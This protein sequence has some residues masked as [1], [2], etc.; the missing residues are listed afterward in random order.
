MLS[1]YKEWFAVAALGSTVL[2]QVRP[3]YSIRQSYFLTASI[4]LLLE[5]LAWVV[6][7]VILW[8][9]YLS[10]LRHLP[11]PSGGSFL[12]GHFKAIRK[13][14][15]GIPAR[16]WLNTIPNDGLIRY[17][18]LG[19]RERI[20]PTSPE[21]LREV[22]VT[23]S[24]I[25]VK[26]WQVAFTLRRMLGN[27]VLV[28]EGDVHRT[29]RKHLNPAFA[30][31]HIKELYPIFW[32]KALE[33]NR[34]LEQHIH[35][36]G[37]NEIEAGDWVSRATLDIIGLAG[38]GLE[39]DSLDTPDNLL[40]S[41]Y[42]IVLSPSRASQILGLLGQF[43]SPR[44]TSLLPIKRN[45]ELN[46]ASKVARETARDLIQRKKLQIKEKGRSDNDIISVALES[47]FFTEENLVDQMMTF[48]LAG[49]ETTATAMQW[50]LLILCRNPT[51]QT[52]L[53]SE[54]HSK[55]SP[56][57]SMTSEL[58][59]ALPYLHGFCMEVLRFYAPVPLTL[60]IASQDTTILQQFIPKGTVIIVSPWAINFSEALWGPDASDFKPERW[61]NAEGTR[62]NNDGGAKSN[63]AFLTFLHGAHNCIG[64]GFAVAEFKALVATWVGYWDTELRD[65]DEQ[66]DIKAGVTAKPRNGMNVKIRSA[67]WD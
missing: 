62:P 46:D 24:Y 8:P 4:I 6:Y 17:L 55:L 36:S 63:F 64:Q 32:D 27:G 9:R 50:A 2:A 14:P 12:N 42:K 52:R 40:H 10:P 11:G 51:I 41:S 21:A 49:H 28:A 19:N 20:V 7:A 26:P 58:L 29:Q 31:R 35:S 23:K 5:Y 38:T 56:S 45:E 3:E 1:T 66:L 59:D 18:H 61:L 16:R 44:L 67:Q 43:F 37:S 65:P 25:F 48:L 39:I 57:Q 47:G 30:F 33:L 54:I 22:L 60:R 15:S 34:K 53:R 13:E